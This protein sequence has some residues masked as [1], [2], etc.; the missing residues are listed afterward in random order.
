MSAKE[1]TAEVAAVEPPSHTPIQQQCTL[2]PDPTL[3]SLQE[4]TEQPRYTDS[5]P[6]LKKNHIRIIYNNTNSLKTECNAELQSMITEYLDYE[7][8]ILG[9]IETNWNWSQMEKTTKPLQQAAN[10]LNQDHV[11]I[12][13]VHYQEKHSAANVYQP[14]GVAQLTF[15]PLSN[16]INDVG[17]DDLGR[18]S[19]QEICLNG[20]CSLFTYTGYRPCKAPVNSKKTMTWDQQV[21]G[22]L[23]CGIDDPDP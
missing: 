8:T 12:T 5:L 19:W 7:P 18:W 16:R 1:V 20:T 13:T 22:L 11:K 23:Q 9:I 10:I 4:T 6:P 14:G 3:Q 21:Q 15:K 2:S 17:S